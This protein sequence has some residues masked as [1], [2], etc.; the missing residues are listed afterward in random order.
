MGEK[1]GISKLNGQITVLAGLV[2][3]I[4]VSLFVVMIESAACTGA[5]TRIN[6]I[7][8]L[9]VQSLFSQFSRPVLDKYEVFGGVISEEDKIIST[10]Y[11]YINENCQVNSKN[12]FSN[13]FD[14]YG[15]KIEGINI[16]EIKL[17]TDNQGEYFYDEITGYMK[18]GQFDNNILDS[19]SEMTE[20]SKQEKIELINSE[21]EDRYYEATKIDE[22]VLRLLMYVE[23]VK[24]TSSGFKLFFG[25]LT[26]ANSFVKKLCPDGTGFGITGV[27][28]R[29]IYDAV[30]SKYYDITGSLEMLKSEL[31][32]IKNVYYH[33]LTKGTFID[34]GFRMSA[35]EI[36]NEINSAAEKINNSLE[37]IGEIE[38]DI[39][40]LSINLN[41]SRNVL[42]KNGDVLDAE[43]VGAFAKE[44]D[45]LDKYKT[46]ESI[47]LINIGDLKQKLLECQWVMGEMQLSVSNLANIYMDIDSIDSV[48]GVVDSCVEVCKKYDASEIV[49]NYEGISLG[50]GESISVIEKIQDVLSNNVL[51]MVIEDDSKISNK[52][53]SY[54]DL[55]SAKKLTNN[56]LWE[57]DLG[58]EQLYKDFLYNKYVNLNF[59]SFAN[60]NTEGLLEYEIEYILGKSL[61]D[62]DNL[63]KVVSEMVNLR[64]APNFTYI[65]CDA[66]KKN[67]CWNMAVM[68]L[69]F[70]GVRGIIKSGQYLLMSAWAY[71]EAIN[72]VKILMNGGRVP[73][74]KSADTW[75]T[76]L[77]DIVAKE[78]KNSKP[79]SL[80]GLDYNEYLQLMLF[81]E[82]KQNKIFRTMDMMEINMIQAGYEH[83]RM[84]RY[85]YSLKGSVYFQ[86]RDGVYDYTQKFDFSY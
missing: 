79:D 76:N 33:P 57:F 4:L 6:S 24:T 35:S 16:D 71:G 67:E 68:L 36:L 13:S 53:I 56:G 29:Q 37:L 44:I 73:F 34:W 2:F 74:K 41:G 84:Y 80:N 58:M 81:L 75:R 8:N 54:T 38:E 60:P 25:S 27:N 31:D 3:G 12:F 77:T 32:L 65:L 82:N 78:I 83:I 20:T 42:E 50:K 28:N 47:T 7:V 46:G 45:E 1:D 18:Y 66:A 11:N 14:P 69:G 72:D 52:K 43:V 64:F 9:G 23:G 49:F 5:K 40:T 21:L 39:N 61:K 86:F 59:S 30:A 17:L 10:L 70:T 62:K 85:L 63:K 19:L 22:K 48:Y 15:I 55:S 51:K 26:G